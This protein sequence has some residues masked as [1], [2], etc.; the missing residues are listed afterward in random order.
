MVATK[1]GGC[2]TCVLDGETGLL[3][4]DHSPAAIGAAC[5]RLLSDPERRAVM[6]Q[7]AARFA[8]ERFGLDTMVEQTLAMYRD[9]LP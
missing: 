8:R 9:Q 2:V 1:V 6:G 7:H 4:D 5:A 3:C